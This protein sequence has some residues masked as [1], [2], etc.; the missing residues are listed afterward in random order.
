MN[1]DAK[2]VIQTGEGYWQGFELNKTVA[3]VNRWLQ[4]HQKMKLPEEIK[5]ADIIKI[6][7]YNPTKNNIY[8]DDF[9]VE[10][11]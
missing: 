11:E 5:H 7:L 6:Y 4:Y 3:E 10:I 8:I 9:S 1:H 2:L